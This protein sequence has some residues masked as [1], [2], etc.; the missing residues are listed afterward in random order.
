[1]NWD[2]S[3]C[4]EEFDNAKKRFWASMNDLP[5]DIPLPDPN[6]YID[7]IDWNSIVDPEFVLDL[8]K[9]GKNPIEEQQGEKV[10]IPG[11]FTLLNQSCSG[12]G[13]GIGEAH[14]PKYIECVSSAQVNRHQ[15]NI[16]NPGTQYYT[17]YYAHYHATKKHAWGWDQREHNRRYTYEMGRGAGLNMKTR[18][19]DNREEE[20]IT[21]HKAPEYPDKINYQIGSKRQ[22]NGGGRGN[23]AYYHPLGCNAPN[24]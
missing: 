2:D 5:C 22:N 3:A 8:E 19:E 17:P 14:M 15:N 21:W 20:K 18:Y 6:I 12:S 13:W 24:A 4:R 1:M 23:F 7:D 16:V 9:D 10:L 11:G